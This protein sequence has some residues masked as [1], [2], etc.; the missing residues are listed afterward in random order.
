MPAAGIPQDVS[1]R[2][3]SPQR[4]YRVLKHAAYMT[5]EFI[6]LTGKPARLA[7]RKE[8]GWAAPTVVMEGTG[9]CKFKNRTRAENIR[10]HGSEFME[11]GV[12]EEWKNIIRE[13]K[14]TE[15]MLRIVSPV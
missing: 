8:S 2:I 10:I 9:M 3:K 13:E 14:T 4:H 6:R 5:G 15:S 11:A 7:Q 1:A 12:Q